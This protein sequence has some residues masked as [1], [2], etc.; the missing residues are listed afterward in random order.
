[1][2]KMEKLKK[3]STSV[4]G[5]FKTAIDTCK[6]I[7]KWLGSGFKKDLPLPNLN[8][9]SNILMRWAFDVIL[10][11]HNVGAL[12]QVIR[13]PAGTGEVCG[14]PQLITI[15]GIK[16]FQF[17]IPLK[18]DNQ[19]VEIDTS[20]IKEIVQSGFTHAL[21]EGVLPNQPY[22]NNGNGLSIP[23]VYIDGEPIVS[24]ADITRQ[25]LKLKVTAFW[26]NNSEMATTVEDWR[27]R[28]EGNNSAGGDIDVTDRNF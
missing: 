8:V 22:T 15:N 18:P 19:D 5:G 9:I 24:I 20:D 28:S 6:K 23:I 7:D 3:I 10:R 13:K 25:K 4:I 2:N 1:M 26:V 11:L 27:M 12:P 17:Y 21:E 16:A 14:R